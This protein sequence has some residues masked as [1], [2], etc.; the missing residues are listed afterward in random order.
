MTLD[1]LPIFLEP[2]TTADPI[3]LF[4]WYGIYFI[5][6]GMLTNY[7]SSLYRRTR[8]LEMIDDPTFSLGQVILAGP[9]E[10]MLFR[11]SAIAVSVYLLSL[12]EVGV[13]FA[14]MIAN[15]IWAGLHVRRFG[16]FIFTFI[17]GLFFTKFWLEGFEG[18]WW[19]AIF[20]H[21]FH[22]ALVYLLVVSDK[23]VGF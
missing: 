22:N 2:I 5:V 6:G 7:L 21:S 12:G 4:L 15:G 18:L 8:R 11:G 3:I 1:D 9:I 10:E 20:F 14:L 16:A 13:F 17:L 19:L 23:D